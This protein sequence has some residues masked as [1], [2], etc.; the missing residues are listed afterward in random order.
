VQKMCGWSRCFLGVVLNFRI[1]RE[2]IPISVQERQ[3]QAAVAYPRS[4]TVAP[5]SAR[6]LT[7]ITIMITTLLLL[8][9]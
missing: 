4:A 2:K 9:F 6:S 1:M 8:L 7:T 3:A 5:F